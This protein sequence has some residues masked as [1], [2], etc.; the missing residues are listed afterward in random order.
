[1]GDY[2]QPQLEAMGLMQHRAN[3]DQQIR[4]GSWD[5]R[6]NVHTLVRAS[7]HPDKP[8]SVPMWRT[9]QGT[10]V[11]SAVRCNMGVHIIK[12]TA[13]VPGGNDD[14]TDKALPDEYYLLLS[15][16]VISTFYLL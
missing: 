4:F 8:R 12:I 16:A 2:S 7:D 11:L 6:R 3:I 13:V 1:M 9:E 15:V 5:D 10:N 14:G